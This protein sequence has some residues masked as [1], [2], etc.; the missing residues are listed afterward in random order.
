MVLL[1][2]LFQRCD[3]VFM[4]GTVMQTLSILRYDQS[5]VTTDMPQL[6]YICTE[7]HADCT[8]EADIELS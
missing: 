2:I 5:L 8:A 1:A 7:S 4:N 3:Y 6:A